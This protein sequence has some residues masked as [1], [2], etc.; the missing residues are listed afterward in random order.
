MRRVCV[1]A[2][3][4]GMAGAGSPAAE[5]KTAPPAQSKV[6][7]VDADFL[8]FLGS[9]DTEEQ[10]WREYLES[11]EIRTAAGKPVEPKTPPKQPG[12]RKEEQ[13]KKP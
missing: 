2:V 4:A 6:E 5:P 1:A 13:V 10:E 3:L 12:P 11:R 7:T 9:L 8:E